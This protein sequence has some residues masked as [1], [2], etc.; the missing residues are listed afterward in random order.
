MNGYRRRAVLLSALPIVVLGAGR[1]RALTKKPPTILTPG[2]PTGRQAT[3]VKPPG[4]EDAVKSRATGVY[5]AASLSTPAGHHYDTLTLI[6]QGQA[7]EVHTRQAGGAY[8]AKR[9]GA[10]SI[11]TIAPATFDQLIAAAGGVSRNVEGTAAK[12]HF[13]QL[14]GLAGSTGG[15]STGGGSTVSPCPSDWAAK[16]AV[17][18]AKIQQDP[19][20]RQRYLG[21][22]SELEPARPGR[23]DMLAR[24]VEALPPLV[25]AARAAEEE[26]K[27]VYLSISFDNLFRAWSFEYN[28]QAGY[29]AFNAFGINAVWSIGG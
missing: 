7:I 25:P 17:Q 26:A 14:A 3:F 20:L 8:L 6:N 22:L 2:T 18:R 5:L 19:V 9:P 11:R 12:A 29:T 16:S 24:L 21:C 27:L 1:A 10:Q 23:R 4:I 15:G 13:L 28:P